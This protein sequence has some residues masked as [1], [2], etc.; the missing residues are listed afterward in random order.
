MTY[1]EKIQRWLLQLTVFLIPTNLAYHWYVQTAYLNGRLI[2]YLLPRLYLSDLPVLGVIVFYVFNNRNNIVKS[3]KSNYKI[4]PIP[5]TLLAIYLWSIIHSPAPQAGFWAIAKLFEY[6]LFITAITRQFTKSWFLSAIRTPILITLL[7]QITVSLYQF[8]NQSSLFGYIFMGEPSLES[9]GIVK[10]TYFGVLEVAPYGTTSHPNV[11]AGFL[12]ISFLF[13]LLCSQN[14]PI[15]KVKKA[16]YVS[17][18]GLILIVISLTQSLAAGGCLFVG[19]CLFLARNRLSNRIVRVIVQMLVASSL[20][21]SPLIISTLYH[22]EKYDDNHSISA[23]Y[24][25]NTSAIHLWQQ[26][27]LFGVG[28]SQFI[29]HLPQTSFNGQKTLFLQPPHHLLILILTETG[30]FGMLTILFFTQRYLL[31]AKT[32][33]PTALYLVPLTMLL[34][35]GSTD[36]YPLTLQT[37][38]LLL[39]FSALLPILR[40]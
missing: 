37:G 32:G 30:L 22:S 26:S 36:H 6:T 24:E 5:C 34:V 39:A 18:M 10:N 20:L 27:P 19:I 40:D 23:R 21:L 16:V 7:L 2:D 8:I 4:L 33:H 35:I 13:L 28:P 9:V 15:S 17:L 31:K 29:P 38:Q 14:Q 1:P 12:T 25:L 3:I 11:L